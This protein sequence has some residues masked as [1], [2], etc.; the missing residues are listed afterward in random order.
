MVFL[1]SYKT[2]YE[3]GSGWQT[4]PVN[5]ALWGGTYNS[6]SY[7]GT[8]TKTIYDPCPKGY[9]VV[10]NGTFYNCKKS[11]TFSYGSYL[12]TDDASEINLGWF[13]AAGYRVNDSGL[14]ARVTASIFCW[15]SYSAS[16][17]AS[18]LSSSE[19]NFKPE[20]TS[21]TNH[22]CSCPVRCCKIPDT[23][24]GSGEQAQQK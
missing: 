6:S 9:Q 13:P 19:S 7:S 23:L 14:L 15:S 17:I 21:N 12:V 11:G 18:Y 3:T 1:P 22:S 10:P 20:N 24:G 5:N 16:G 2:L 8:T 4:S